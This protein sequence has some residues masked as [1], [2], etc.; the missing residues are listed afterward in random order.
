MIADCE[1]RLR[2]EIKYRRYPTVNQDTACHQLFGFLEAL[3]M[4]GLLDPCEWYVDPDHFKNIKSEETHMGE[5][6]K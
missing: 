2:H 5:A 1:K 6:L 4:L 3:K